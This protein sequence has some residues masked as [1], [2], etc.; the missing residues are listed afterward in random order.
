MDCN[1]GMFIIDCEASERPAVGCSVWLD[2]MSNKAEIAT[3]NKPQVRKKDQSDDVRIKDGVWAR[4]R[5][6]WR[7]DVQ[8]LTHRGTQLNSDKPD[9]RGVPR[10]RRSLPVRPKKGNRANNPKG[11]HK[12]EPMEH[13]PDKEIYNEAENRGPCKRLQRVLRQPARVHDI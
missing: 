4:W 13:C 8:K 11:R 6:R 2:I 10:K 7:N 12:T 9:E 3:T 1:G 5:M